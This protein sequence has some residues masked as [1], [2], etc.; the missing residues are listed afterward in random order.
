MHYNSIKRTGQPAKFRDV[1][2]FYGKWTTTAG[3]K[4]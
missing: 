3:K 2:G 4:K 1:D